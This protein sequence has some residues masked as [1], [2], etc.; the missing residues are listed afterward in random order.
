MLEFYE[1]FGI[2][3]DEDMARHLKMDLEELTRCLSSGRTPWPYL[4]PALAEA[5]VTVEVFLG[6]MQLGMIRG[7]TTP[8]EG[9]P[10]RVRAR[11]DYTQMLELRKRKI[12]T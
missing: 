1:F 3:S 5:G 11:V 4:I 10:L 2:Y 6:T 9:L 7:L 8:K 12:L